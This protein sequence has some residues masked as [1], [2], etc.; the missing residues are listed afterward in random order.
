MADEKERPFNDILE[1]LALRFGFQVYLPRSIYVLYYRAYFKL[2][3]KDLGVLIF[4][5]CYEER[6]CGKSE[7]ALNTASC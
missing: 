1:W 4:S 3:I 6:K 7:G 2:F 5:F